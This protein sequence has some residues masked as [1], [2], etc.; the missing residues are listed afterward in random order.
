MFIAIVVHD[1]ENDK[2]YEALPSRGQMKKYTNHALL[3]CGWEMPKEL[4]RSSFARM[5]H[6]EI[7]QDEWTHAGCLSSCTHR[8]NEKCRW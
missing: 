3:S 8:G 2:Y 6:K 5:P 1:T 4:P 7:S